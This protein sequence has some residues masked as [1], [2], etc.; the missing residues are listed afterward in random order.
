MLVKLY[1]VVPLRTWQKIPEPSGQ[2]FSVALTIKLFCKSV[3]S[4]RI[5][6]SSTWWC[7]QMETSSALLALCVGNSPVTDEVPSQRPVTRSFDVFFEPR[8]NK[9]FIKQSRRRWFEKPSCSSLQWVAVTLWRHD[10]IF[11]H[12]SS[13]TP[14]QL[15]TH[16]CISALWLLMHWC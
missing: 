11:L 16:G 8:L 15:G 3:G 14:K 13:L 5:S 9:R 10:K 4:S 12:H 1:D 7:H 2:V 6:N